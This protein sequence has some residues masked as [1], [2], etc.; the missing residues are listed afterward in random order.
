MKRLI[1][2]FLCLTMIV[3]C[4]SEPKGVSYEPENSDSVMLVFGETYPGDD[5]TAMPPTL[6]YE[7]LSGSFVTSNKK[8]VTK[9]LRTDTLKTSASIFS[10]SD[11]SARPIV[12]VY[13]FLSPDY[14]GR[15][16]WIDIYAENKNLLS[17]EKMPKE[18]YALIDSLIIH[19][20]KSQLH[21][22]DDSTAVINNK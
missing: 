9:P 19:V 13:T 3:G 6:S 11:S 5:T 16:K 21:W 22:V 12:K 2:L 4:E 14:Q 20:K 18:Q 1:P 8:S 17:I 10:I 7:K 15:N